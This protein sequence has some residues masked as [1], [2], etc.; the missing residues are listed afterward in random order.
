MEQS[1]PEILLV[2][3]QKSSWLKILGYV[4]IILSLIAIISAII[5]YAASGQSKAI[6]E[7]NVQTKPFDDE[8]IEETHVFIKNDF[9]EAGAQV[10][11][12]VVRDKKN[13]LLTIHMPAHYD[14]LESTTV[15]DVDSVSIHFKTLIIKGSKPIINIIQKI[16]IV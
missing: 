6:V 10:D 13:G 7:I 3:N 14:K 9:N 4:A 11:Q 12:K 2:K 1:E 16:K 15:F 8:D 5:S